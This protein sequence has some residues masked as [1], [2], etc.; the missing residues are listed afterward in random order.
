M[1][2]K[3]QR[4]ADRA[5]AHSE[6]IVQKH[7]RV[8]GAALKQSTRLLESASPTACQKHLCEAD[9]LKARAAAW[10]VVHRLQSRSQAALGVVEVAAVLVVGTQ[11]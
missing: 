3:R 9:P 5:D 1:P 7:G 2:A 8:V 6:P 10:I 11:G 4:H